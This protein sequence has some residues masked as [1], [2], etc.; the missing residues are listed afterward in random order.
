MAR[1]NKTKEEVTNTNEVI[2]SSI[3]TAEAEDV[4]VADSNKSEEYL[5]FEV[6]IEEYKKQSPAKFELKKDQ[7]F[8][9]LNTL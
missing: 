6:F 1:P 3:E 9:K 5:K 4:F 2:D 8:A 7:L